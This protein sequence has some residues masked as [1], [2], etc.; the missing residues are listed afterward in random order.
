MSVG[1]LFQFLKMLKFGIWHGHVFNRAICWSAGRGAVVIYSAVFANKEMFST[2]HDSDAG[3]MAVN[4]LEFSLSGDYDSLLLRGRKVAGKDLAGVIH[5]RSL[6]TVEDEKD[7]LT[8]AI[9]KAKAT[10]KKMQASAESAATAMRMA[11]HSLEEAGLSGAAMRAQAQSTWE[12]M[13]ETV[14][15]SRKLAA[16]LTRLR[17]EEMG[18]DNGRISSGEISAFMQ[19]VASSRRVTPLTQRSMVG[20]GARAGA[21]PVFVGCGSYVAHNTGVMTN[22]FH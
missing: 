4:G 15:K 20:A 19:R 9:A 5:C 7:I 1:S 18:H 14:E 2:E 6:V 11:A 10:A 12:T 8:V 22:H 16:D 17:D 21:E 3:S 13:M